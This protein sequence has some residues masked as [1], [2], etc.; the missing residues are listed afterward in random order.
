MSSNKYSRISPDLLQTIQFNAGVLASDFSI[1]TGE[2]SG[3]IGAT[4]SGIN[5]TMTPEF[6]DFGEGIDNCP[7]ATKDLKRIT[8]WD[9]KISGTFVGIDPSL[10]GK[11][12]GGSSTSSDALPQDAFERLIHSIVPKYDIDSSAFDD[13]WWIGDMDKSVGEGVEPYIAIKMMNAL[14]TGGFQI[15]TADKDKGQFSFEF[16]AHS[17]LS[18]PY[19]VPCHI[20]MLGSVA[21]G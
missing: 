15:Q 13:I 14:S 21:G 8:G 16:T 3:I 9:C 5:V 6:V 17:T 20:Y 19:T 4:S 18:D 2:I 11:L 12:L 7:R 1:E 10:A